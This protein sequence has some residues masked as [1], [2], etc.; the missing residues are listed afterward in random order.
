VSADE[1]SGGVQHGGEVL[2]HVEAVHLG[3]EGEGVPG[4]VAPPEA[5]GEHGAGADADGQ[6]PAAVT[7]TRDTPE[8]AGLLRTPLEA[9]ALAELERAESVERAA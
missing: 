6:R 4:E 5:L 3:D 1:A 9:E 2:A 7:R 8:S